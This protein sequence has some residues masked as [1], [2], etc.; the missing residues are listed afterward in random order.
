MRFQAVR[1]VVVAAAFFALAAPY[2]GV[3]QLD[4]SASD[5]RQRQILDRIQEIESQDGPYSPELLEQLMGL[6]LLYRESGDESLAVVAIERALQVVRANSGLYSLE[7]V[8]LMWLRI[9]A[10]EALR[11]DAEVWDLEQ[12]LLTLVRRHPDDL[13]AAPILHRM[14]DRQMAVL[15]RVLDGETPP[16]VRLGCFYKTWP[17]DGGGSCDAGSRKDVVQGMLAEAQRNYADA[18]AIMLRN[19]AYSS[20]ELRELEMELLRGADLIRSEYD[21]ERRGLTGSRVLTRKELPVPL[22]PGAVV[23]EI[24]EPWRSRTEP[25]RALAEWDLPYE[26]VEEDEQNFLYEYETREG[27][28]GDPYHRGRQSLRRLH[29]YGAA[30]SSTPLRQATAIVMLADWDLLF[31][32]HGFALEGYELARSMLE[33]A[34]E[35]EAPLAQLFAPPIPVVLPAFRPNPLLEDETRPSTGYID[36]AFSI[37]KYGRGRDVEIL[38]GENASD[39]AKDDFIALVR[40]SRFRPQL[41]DGELSD[42]SPVVVRYYLYD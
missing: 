41:T 31:S 24:R 36:V 1:A 4:A 14:A 27:R 21:D 26:S 23:S 11:N 15:D 28:L 2:V 33:R 39:P 20:D 7:Q 37:T 38:G 22:V 35:A 16:Q 10:E 12:D 6:I 8:P 42:A 18:I 3:A 5:E 34:G 13:G 29:A 25:L 40:S 17:N 30:T 32:Y 19:E 9:E